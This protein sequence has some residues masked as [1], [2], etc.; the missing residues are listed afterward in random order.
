MFTYVNKLKYIKCQYLKM[1]FRD[2]NFIVIQQY[3]QPLSIFIHHKMFTI[4]NYSTS[5]ENNTR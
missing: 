3:P 4:L 1:T 5:T 2:D